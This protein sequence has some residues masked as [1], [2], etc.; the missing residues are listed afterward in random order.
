M[1]VFP[2]LNFAIY[3]SANHWCIKLCVSSVIFCHI[4]FTLHIYELTLP[5]TTVWD[6]VSTFVSLI[7]VDSLDETSRHFQRRLRQQLGYFW[8]TIGTILAVFV[9]TKPGILSQNSIFSEPLATCFYS[10][11]QPDNEHKDDKTFP[12]IVCINH[13]FLLI[14]NSNISLLV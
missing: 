12:C 14:L 7:P 1:S 11:T 2:L 3:V 8:G 9:T 10:W 4:T 13:T 6:D 5:E